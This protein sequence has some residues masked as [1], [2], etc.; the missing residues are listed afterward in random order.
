MPGG[1]KFEEIRVINIA[2]WFHYKIAIYRVWK[3]KKFLSFFIFFYGLI[4]L[5]KSF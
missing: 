2:K 5:I 1:M 3:A 4:F